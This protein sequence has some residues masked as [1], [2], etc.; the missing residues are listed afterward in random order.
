MCAPTPG[1]SSPHR[2]RGSAVTRRSPPVSG[3][4]L[5][6]LEVGE[7]HHDHVAECLIVGTVI[8]R[9]HAGRRPTTNS[10][11]ILPLRSAR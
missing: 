9:F 6:R 1:A 5:W 8:A 11:T 2:R 10:L 7:H 3:R 4:T